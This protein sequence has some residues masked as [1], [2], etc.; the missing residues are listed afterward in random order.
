MAASLA[1][2]A[3][4]PN[5]A[6][7]IKRQEIQKVIIDRINELNLPLVQYKNNTEFVLLV[8]NLI[9]HLVHNKKGKPK[10]DKKALAIEIL[11]QVLHLSARDAGQLGSNI[12]FLH[13]NK[14]IKKVSKFYAFCCGVAEYFAG[15][16]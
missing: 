8:L 3:I 1:L 2:V 14:M 10:I 9:E 11:T 13:S 7:D 12:D 6:L 4:Q 15:K 5:L 16:K